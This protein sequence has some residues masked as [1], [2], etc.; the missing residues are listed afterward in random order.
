[1]LKSP[2][3][4][5]FLIIGFPLIGQMKFR[6]P[7]EAMHHQID[8]FSSE[9]TK[10][11][12]DGKWDNIGRIKFEDVTIKEIPLKV[13]VEIFP[14]QNTWL[15]SVPGT[16]Q[17]YQL[18]IHKMIMKRLDNSFYRGYNFQA[19]QYI[20]NDTIFSHGGVGFWHANNV[21][22][23]FSIKSKEW[24]MTSAPEETGPRWM[25][26][27][28]GGYDEGRNVLSVIEFPALYETKNQV[29]EYRYFEKDIRKNHWNFLGDV[30]VSL[31]QDLGIKRFESDFLNG[32]YFFLNGPILVWA[33]PTSNSLYQ[34]NTVIP[35][36]NM[37]FELEFQKGYIYSYR[38]MNAP[39]NEEGIFKIDSI[40]IDKLKSLSTYKGPFYIEP[41]PTNL[42]GYGAAAIL[43][44]SA[45]GIYVYRKRKPRKAHES[46]IEPLD[47]LPAGASEFLLACLNHPQGHAFSSQHFT[48]MMG[49]GSY[50]Y[51][52]QRQVRAKLI[53]G[54]N[55]YFWAHYRMDDVIIRQ[56]AN[57]D[58]RFSVYL[59]AESH[60]DNLKKLLNV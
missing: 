52:T 57:D 31:L 55:S 8:L 41:Y 58:K 54:V 48:E 46:I 13:Q 45:G 50:A 56:T 59:I 22:T 42:I 16:Q 34:A 37:N 25:Q 32:K 6:L 33:D 30:H 35:M 14:Y 7:G 18:D 21:S 9:L 26:S 12:R 43:I 17:V 51:E 40:S 19:I 47:G 20:R 23:Y 36:F 24:E 38:R 5:L 27:D 1:M 11:T 49:Y 4:L 28:F 10:E 39:T 15:L 53:K 2:L 44:L 60:Y 29:K 3:F